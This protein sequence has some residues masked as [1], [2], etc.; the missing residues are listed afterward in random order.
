MAQPRPPFT[1]REYIRWRNS[2]K[3][4]QEA[5]KRWEEMGVI[6]LS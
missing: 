2:T 4:W 3:E 1:T 5:C 6:V